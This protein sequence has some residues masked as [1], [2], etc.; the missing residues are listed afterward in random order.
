MIMTL[1]DRRLSRCIHV[2]AIATA[3]AALAMFLPAMRGLMGDRLTVGVSLSVAALFVGLPA[4]IGLVAWSDRSA[5]RTPIMSTYLVLCGV[6]AAFA[7]AVSLRAA[8]VG[9]SPDALVYS[10]GTLGVS[11]ALAVAAAF[12]RDRG[13]GAIAA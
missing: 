1:D 4:M 2:L 10:S 9:G 3:I 12:I 6:V 13:H 7:V 8:V 5:R 11:I